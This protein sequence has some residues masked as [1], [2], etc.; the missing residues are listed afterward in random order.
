MTSL[1]IAKNASL[2]F[3]IRHWCSH[4]SYWLH[5]GGHL[6]LVKYW[7][8]KCRWAGHWSADSLNSHLLPI[9]IIALSA[10]LYSVILVMSTVTHSPGSSRC[11]L[12][13][14]LSVCRWGS[15]ACHLTQQMAPTKN[16]SQ[17]LRPLVQTEGQRPPDVNVVIKNWSLFHICK[18]HNYQNNHMQLYH[19]Q[20]YLLEKKVYVCNFI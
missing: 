17:W 15:M 20:T 7:C 5:R 1:S 9:N 2:C 4:L 3:W 11:W 6:W 8:R 13:A 14:A 18:F 10:L 19:Q 12:V 16:T